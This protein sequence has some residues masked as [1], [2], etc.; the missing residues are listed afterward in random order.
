VSRLYRQCGALDITQPTRPVTKLAF[1]V[2]G[3]TRREC[4]LAEPTLRV[5]FPYDHVV[6]TDSAEVQPRETICSW[7][8]Q[9]VTCAIGATNPAWVRWFLHVTFSPTWA[10]SEAKGTEFIALDC[11][12]RSKS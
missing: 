5:Y 3:Y 2:L 11:T 1:Y 12:Q 6:G 8:A 10:V 4:G 7:C 9:I